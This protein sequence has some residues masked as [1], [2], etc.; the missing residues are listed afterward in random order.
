MHLTFSAYASCELNVLGH[1]GNSF[2]VDSA[3]IAVFKESD[4][5]GFCGLLQHHDCRGLEPNLR[6]EI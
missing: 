4:D 3:Q 5:I 6:V 2:G 1:D